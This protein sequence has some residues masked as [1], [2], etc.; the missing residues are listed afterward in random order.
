MQVSAACGSRA[1]GGTASRQ[2]DVGGKTV[3][4]GRMKPTGGVITGWELVVCKHISRTD[5]SPAETYYGRRRTRVRSQAA[6]EG[7]KK[8]VRQPPF[9]IREHDVC[10]KARQSFDYFVA[11]SLSPLAFARRER[12]RARGARRRY[13]SLTN[14]FQSAAFCARFTDKAV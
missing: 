3:I 12:D 1:D 13:G 14:D 10:S 6:P 4:D 5:A 11:R 2:N 7:K 8:G 9:L